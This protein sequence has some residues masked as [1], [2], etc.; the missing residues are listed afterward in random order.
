MNQ[1]QQP[2]R[3]WDGAKDNWIVLALVALVITWLLTTTILFRFPL[4]TILSLFRWQSWDWRWL[5]LL[6]L[7]FLSAGV[8]Y[9]TVRRVW[10]RLF[11]L[12]GFRGKTIWDLFGLL[13]VPVVIVLAGWW[14]GNVST[15]K[16][17]Q[18]EG[19][20]AQAQQQIE[21]RRAQDSVLQ[22]YIQDMTTLL[23]DK[24][25]AASKQDDPVRSIA[26]SSTLTAVRQLDADRKG[27]LLQFLYESNLIMEFDPTIELYGAD[28]SDAILRRNDPIID[29]Y[30]AD[31]SGADLYDA[32]LSNANLFG[33][34]LS[35]ADL[36]YA[37][38]SGADLSFAD[39]SD[40][41][42]SF[43]RLSSAVLRYADLRG[44]SLFGVDLSGANLSDARNWTNE[45]LSQA[46]SLIEVTM[47][48]RTKMTREHWEE[49]KERHRQ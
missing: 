29:L 1:D 37:D 27:I 5:V 36:S 15:Q 40:A 22:L 41:D 46:A 6:G 42:L 11:D 26:R 13:I 10:N 19:Q 31:L 18:I 23:L 12:M 28:L 33:A 2:R 21:D 43:V 35:G 49:F 45:Q 20:R 32:N 9:L 34:D 17:Q 39:L 3:W 16:Q 25:L 14:L 24:R 48:D 7:I 47:P 38:L 44:A 4:T 30:G 8:L